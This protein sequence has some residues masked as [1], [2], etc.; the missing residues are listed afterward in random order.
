M[1]SCRV[2]KT[3]VPDLIRDPFAGRHDLAM[4]DRLR[5]NDRSIGLHKR[6]TGGK[7]NRQ[8]FVYI[9]ASKRN[10]TLYTGVTSD[11]IRRVYEHKNNLVEGFTNKYRVHRLVYFEECG[12]IHMAIAREKQIKNWER[13]WKKNLIEKE[14]P[15]WID[16]YDQLT[17]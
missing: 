13:T 4:D 6:N 17:A 7:V 9:L 5:R 11:L 15:R 12:D 1:M 10:G 8:Y 16:L 3:V 14:N 2:K